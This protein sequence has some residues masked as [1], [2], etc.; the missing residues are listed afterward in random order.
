MTDIEV[1]KF[2]I[3]KQLKEFNRG[4]KVV[5]VLDSL[6]NLASKKEVDDAESGKSVADMSRAKAI[7]SLFRMVTPHLNLLNIPM[8]VVNHTYK[9]MSLFPVDVV[10]GGTGSYLSADNIY[11]ISR[12]QIKEDD[13]VS[14]YKFTINV[15]KSRH[16]KEKTK[17]P[18]TVTFDEGISKYSGLLEVAVE[19][20]FVS[21]EKA[22]KSMVYWDPNNDTG[23]KYKEP[24]T[25]SIAFWGP[26]LKDPEF[27]KYIKDR[28]AAAGGDIIKEELTDVPTE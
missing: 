22:G 13:K 16:V 2:D 28:F 9:S 14:G 25:N 27:K 15:E 26:I 18:I 8:V 17:I 7:K 21:G 5:I 6:G 24:D 12:N 11:I 19:G 3:M 4:D 10:S 20:G 23:N 1:L